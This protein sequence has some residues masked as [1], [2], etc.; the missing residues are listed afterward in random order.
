[1]ENK[2]WVIMGKYSLKTS[3]LLLKSICSLTLTNIKLLLEILDP[4]IIN[5]SIGHKKAKLKDQ[6]LWWP[7]IPTGKSILRQLGRDLNSGKLP[8]TW[9]L[10]IRR[11]ELWARYSIFP[12]N[13]KWKRTWDM[14][15]CYDHH[16]YDYASLHSQ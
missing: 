16:D 13:N 10:C 4:L 12:L 9:H 11:M 5:H 7:M 1:M 2:W 8:H 15:L 6:Y 3:K 14:L